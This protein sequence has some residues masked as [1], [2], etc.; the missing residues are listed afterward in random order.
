MPAG[1]EEVEV[2]V[3][4]GDVA[5]AEN[6]ALAEN[7][8]QKRVELFINGTGP[9]SDT[10]S[11]ITAEPSPEEQVEPSPSP[12]IEGDLPLEPLPSPSPT[13]PKSTPTPDSARLEGTITLDVDPTTGLIAVETCP[14]IRTKT[15]VLGTEPKKFCGPEYHKLKTVDPGASRPRTTATPQR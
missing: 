7:V 3:G 10:A 5:Q 14:V 12:S 11:T 4:T 13:R 1:V 2:S 8:V 6:V 9:N 15:F